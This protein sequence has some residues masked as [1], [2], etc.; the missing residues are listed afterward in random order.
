MSLLLRSTGA[1]Q[2]AGNQGRHGFS[3]GNAQARVSE[4][5]TLA[6]GGY[7][8]AGR[9]PARVPVAL[10]DSWSEYVAAQPGARQGV[11]PAC[12][13]PPVHCPGHGKRTKRIF[14]YLRLNGWA[15]NER[16]IPQFGKAGDA[17]WARTR[18][19]EGGLRCADE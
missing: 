3:W 19:S 18:T 11:Q 13:G 12:A 10:G 6:W 1:G 2:D 8:G 14:Q 4:E 17:E 5:D 16:N 7:C 15:K 9:N